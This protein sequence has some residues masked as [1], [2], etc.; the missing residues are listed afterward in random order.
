MKVGR[1]GVLEIHGYRQSTYP[2]ATHVGAQPGGPFW[3]SLLNTVFPLGAT[4]SL[5]VWPGHLYIGAYGN[6]LNN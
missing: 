1:S 4:C 5:T 2:G 6:R 3:R